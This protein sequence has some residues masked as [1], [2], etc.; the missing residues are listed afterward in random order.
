V[1]FGQHRWRGRKGGFVLQGLGLGVDGG[2]QNRS[3][4]RMGCWPDVVFC[5]AGRVV[6]RGSARRLDLHWFSSG[7]GH[8]TDIDGEQENA[9][10]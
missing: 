10:G 9:D 8:D 7:I 6:K 1:W 3:G 2:L 5:V 4:K